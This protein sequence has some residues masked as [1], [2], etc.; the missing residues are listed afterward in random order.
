M[1]PQF[2]AAAVAAILPSTNLLGATMKDKI[3]I[4]RGYLPR[5][6]WSRTEAAAYIRNL[7]NVRTLEVVA[8]SITRTSERIHIEFENCYN[9]CETLYKVPKS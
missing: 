3:Y 6:Q 9:Y 4:Q 8:A 5:G 1:P 2:T 7:R